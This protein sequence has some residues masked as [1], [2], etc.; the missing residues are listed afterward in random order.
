MPVESLPTRAVLATVNAVDQTAS[1][2]SATSEA[3]LLKKERILDPLRSVT[4]W[5]TSS[6]IAQKIAVQIADPFAVPALFGLV[7]CNVAGGQTV[8]L[9][10]ATE[11]SFDTAHANYVRWDFTTYTQ[12]RFRRVHRAYPGTPSAPA[13]PSSA[14]REFWQLTL[15]ANG[16]QDGADHYELGVLFLAPSII[17]V[18]LAPDLQR[19]IVDPSI[20][21]ASDAGAPFPDRRRRYHELSLGSQGLTQAESRAMIEAVEENGVSV[22][23][24][25]DL[26]GQATDDAKKAEGTYYGT[27]G[28]RDEVASFTRRIPVRDAFSMRFSEARA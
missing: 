1:V 12:N 28:R 15:P 11:S 19:T 21:P 23:A 17:S 2:I 14:V 6:T 5:S 7:N 22:H 24:M 9:E 10:G 8:K 27:L 16:T 25:L 26:W 20:V 3:S 4:W 18:R 13:S